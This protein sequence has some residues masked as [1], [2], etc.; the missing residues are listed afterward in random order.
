MKMQSGFK[1]IY[2]PVP[3]WRLGSSLGVDLLSQEEKIC[4]FD[5]IYCQLGPV[6]KYTSE[7]KIYV[8]VKEVIKELGALPGV[9]IDYITFSGRG[10]PTLAANLG[11]AI[12]TVKS[13]R[14]ER[15]AV[16]TNSSLMGSDAVRNELFLADFV[17]AKL[18]AGSAGSLQEINRPAQGVGFESIFEGIKVFQKNYRG[19]L[20]LQMMFVDNN[21]NDVNKLIYLTNYIQPDEIQV[22]TPLRPCGIRALIKEEILKIKDS[23]IASC[24]GINVVSIYDARALKDIV[25]L[26]DEDTLR[27]RGKIK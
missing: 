7:R 11:E 13:I 2:G 9:N 10:E 3:S 4:N 23:F 26:S 14:K 27:R 24:K 5:C 8:P 15:I 6:K 19:K 1:Y 18:D 12:K 25:S 22:N 17:V 20:A 16:L 21:K